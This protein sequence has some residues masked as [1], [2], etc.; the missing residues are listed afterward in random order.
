MFLPHVL[1]EGPA[2]L[3]SAMAPLLHAHSDVELISSD[4]RKSCAPPIP[5]A[6][7]VFEVKLATLLHSKESLKQIRGAS[8][9]PGTYLYL[10]ISA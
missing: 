2:Y 3:Q 6:K 9:R 4:L 8:F 7:N 1:V 10:V 5:C